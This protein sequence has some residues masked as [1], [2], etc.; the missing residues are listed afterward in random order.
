[1]VSTPSNTE[2]TVSPDAWT[3]T[4]T[5]AHVVGGVVVKLGGVIPIQ[6]GAERPSRAGGLRLIRPNAAPL[7]SERNAGRDGFLGDA[8][9][10]AELVGDASDHAAGGCDRVENATLLSK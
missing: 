5:D 8:E 4:Q 9:Q 6:D 3:L 2:P 10:R 7:V 1:M